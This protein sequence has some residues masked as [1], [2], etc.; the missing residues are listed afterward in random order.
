VEG[1][2][3]VAAVGARI[4]ERSDQVDVLDKRARI[5]MGE[6]QWQSMRLGRLHVKEVDRLPVDDGGELWKGVELRF[7]RPPVEARTP[8]VDEVLQVVAGNAA[9]PATSGELLGQAGVRQSIVEVGK[10][11][12]RD[13][14]PKRL[15]GVGGGVAA[16][17]GHGGFLSAL[18]SRFRSGTE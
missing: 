15:Q 9:A 16:L 11:G 1:V 2:G 14:D 8:V 10:I 17:I 18:H 4:G 12:V 5:A 13:I 6:D 7:L 3:G